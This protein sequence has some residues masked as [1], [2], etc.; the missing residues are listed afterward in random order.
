MMAEPGVHPDTV[1][2]MVSVRRAVPG[3]LERLLRLHAAFCAADGHDYSLDAAR[4]AFVPLLES[5]DI[6]MV[7]VADTPEGDGYLV[8]TWG[9]SIESGGRDAL[10]DEVY[11]DPRDAGIGSALV[12]ATLESLS[13]RRV[14]RVFLETEGDNEAARR[15]YARFGFAVEPSV[16]MSREL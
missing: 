13:E 14:S 11:A 4:R 9:W 16:W 1:W 12:E 15:L 3:D 8:V 7:W 6:G 10:L 5:D 2:I